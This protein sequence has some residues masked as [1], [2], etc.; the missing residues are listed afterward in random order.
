MKVT[1]TFLGNF[2]GFLTENCKLELFDTIIQ[3]E[4]LF[5][6]LLFFTQGVC[7]AIILYKTGFQ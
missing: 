6:A 7:V 3:T 1:A 5:D 4:Q 2:F